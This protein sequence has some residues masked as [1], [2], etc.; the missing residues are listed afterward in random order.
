M[1]NEENGNRCI[2]LICKEEIVSEMKHRFDSPDSFSSH[3]LNALASALPSQ[4]IS[5]MSIVISDFKDGEYLAVL[6][7]AIENT[8]VR[9]NA[10]DAV[11]LAVACR[12]PLFAKRE[13]LERYGIPYVPAS[14]A[15]P[16]P[17]AVLPLDI[18][19]D[20]MDEAVQFEDYETAA[21]IRNEIRRR[22]D[23]ESATQKL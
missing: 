23:E 15:I 17:C 19:K 2:A 4:I 1:L 5:E 11:L 22:E 12:I 9:M 3:P 18:L 10:A 14:G 16:M 6:R 13:F 7:Y 20:I 21:L 8:E